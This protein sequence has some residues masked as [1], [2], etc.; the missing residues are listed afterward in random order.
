MSPSQ[1]FWFLLFSNQCNQNEEFY[2]IVNSMCTESQATLGL[3]FRFGF[4]TSQ[5][6]VYSKQ[7]F[8]LRQ[9]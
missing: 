7:K 6:C 9:S 5:S 8:I 2:K 3:D 4:Q 1:V